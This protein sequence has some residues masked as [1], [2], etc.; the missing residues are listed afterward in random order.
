MIS[1]D[2]W[3]LKGSTNVGQSGSGLRMK[4]YSTFPNIVGLEPHYQ[5]QF[6]VIPRTLILG[7]SAEVQLAYS[8]AP[9]DK[10]SKHELT[11]RKIDKRKYFPDNNAFVSLLFQSFG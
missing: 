3:D 1:D 8:I 2:M 5:M 9:A 4:E 11:W 6:N 7:G 10:E